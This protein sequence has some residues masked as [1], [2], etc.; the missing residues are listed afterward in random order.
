[1]KAQF[2]KLS[3]LFGVLAYCVAIIPVTSSSAFAAVTSKSNK[4]LL[5]EKI[6]INVNEKGFFD[7]KGQ[8]LGPDNPLVV[9]KGNKVEITFVFNEG[10]TSLA[11]GDVHQMAIT[12]KDGWTLE[13]EKIWVFNRMSSVSFLPGENGRTE[14][15]A[16]CMIDCIGMDHLNN[17]V[18]KVVG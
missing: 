5:V 16:Y 12:S 7:S 14:Y 17:L 18:I 1:M 15:R 8:L 4:E 11:I 2:S 6:I 13:S 9:N 10:M 3:I